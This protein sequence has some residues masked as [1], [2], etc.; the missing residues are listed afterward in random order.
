M[1]DARRLRREFGSIVAVDD[2]SLT[3]PEGTILALLGPNG[4]GK[5]TT[6]RLLAGLLAP[7]AGEASVAGCDVRTEPAAIRS[8]VGLV[9]DTPG[10]HEQMTPVGYLNFFGRVYGLDEAVRQRR[11]DELLRLFDLQAVASARMAG[12]SRGMQQKVALARALLHEPEVVFLD[13]PTAGLDPLAARTVRE[14]IVG[15]KHASRSIVLCTHDLDEAERLADRV[16]ILAHGRIV[17]SD[18]AAALRAHASHETLVQILLAAP[19]AAAVTIAERVAGVA[20]PVLAESGQGPLLVYRTALT[21][22]TNPHVIAGLVGAGAS[23]VS[24]TCTTATLEDVYATAVGSPRT[25]VVGAR[26]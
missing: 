5:T 23:I 12:F 9:T 19:C 24:V 7:T 26:P 11:I 21:Q 3:V 6:V 18:S 20:D 13:E 2:I 1:I 22:E 17:A 25:D 14:L 10:L 8:R 15:L 16:A 4:A